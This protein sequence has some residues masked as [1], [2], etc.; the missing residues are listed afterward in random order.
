MEPPD[1][2]QHR[3]WRRFAAAF[4]W[5]AAGLLGGYLALATLVD[6][7][8]S[9]RS[10]L[11]SAG[12]VRPQGPRT[13]AASRGRDPAFTGA[14]IGNSHI[15]LVEP[16]RLGALT[17][18]PFVQLSVPATGPGEQFLL[19]DWYLRHHP[20]PAALV[21]AADE[22]WCTD[23]PALPNAKPFPFWLFSD[24]VPA[25][26]RGLMR[27]SVAQEV[28]GRIG[29]LL[30]ARR[31]LAR[32][33]GWWDYEPDYLR[34]GYADDPRLVADRD[35]RAPDAPDPGRA[36]PF[37]AAERFAALLARVPAATP[38]LLVFPP[39]YAPGLPRPGTAREAAEAA[40][41][42]AVRAALATHP[43]S[44]VLDWR[45]DRPELHDSAQF[46]DQTH[47]RHPLARHLTDEMGASLRRLL[48]S[49]PAR[50]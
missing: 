21:V 27:F 9:G 42:G 32:A 8:D 37:P 22:Y 43:A 11:L 45:R 14:I 18:I 7:Y 1:I 29:W 2:A 16:S 46:F 44:A 41:K 15:Q 50:E 24:S 6:P 30:R 3:S 17:G 39:L 23:D 33:D 19:L 36:G 49:G 10:R 28:V 31:P 48:Q 35:K 38:V 12:G 26:L 47:Y 20:N 5:T 25:Y 34:Q 40:C 13:A 4:A